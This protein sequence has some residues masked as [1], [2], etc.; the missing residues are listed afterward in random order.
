MGATPESVLLLD[1]PSAGKE[2][3]DEGAGAG[4]LFLQVRSGAV[5]PGNR[6]EKPCRPR[7]RWQG[8]QAPEHP[9]HGCLLGRGRYLACLRSV[10]PAPETLLSPPPQ[11][12][13]VNGV[14]LRT[15]VD[16][17]TGQLRCGPSHPLQACSHTDPS[18]VSPWTH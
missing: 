12:G 6:R 3:T 2:G 5:E 14:L 4:A 1:S 11:V 7:M 18:S 13:L 15:E 16:R 8:I 10:C 9:A 17:V